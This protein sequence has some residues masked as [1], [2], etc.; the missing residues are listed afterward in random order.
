MP[1]TRLLSDLLGCTHHEGFSEENFESYCL[2][3]KACYELHVITNV[4]VR[5]NLKATAS[6][7]KHAM[8]CMSRNQEGRSKA[9]L[10]PHVWWVDYARRAQTL[11]EILETLSHIYR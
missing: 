9:Q 6:C 8:S 4:S 3:C 1:F 7:V 11:P 2:M 10:L 5:R